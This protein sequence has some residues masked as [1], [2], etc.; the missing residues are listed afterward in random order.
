MI[1]KVRQHP[2]QNEPLLFETSSPGKSG[3]QLPPLDVPA[4]DAGEVLGASQVRREIE[5]FPEVSEVEAIFHLQL[6]NRPV[7]LSAWLLHD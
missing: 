6:S 1:R 4:V 5:D 2:T 3:Y 7:S